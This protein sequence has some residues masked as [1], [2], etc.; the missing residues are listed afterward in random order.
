MINENRQENERQLNEP[1]L[2]NGKTKR[3]VIPQLND[4]MDESLMMF[5]S[6]GG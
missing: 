2:S 4:T 3:M 6:K 5:Q 1:L